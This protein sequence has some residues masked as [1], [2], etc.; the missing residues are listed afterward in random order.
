MSKREVWPPRCTEC[1][2][3]ISYADMELGRTVTYTP[4][5][6]PLDEEPPADEWMHRVCW[7][8]MGSRQQALVN[9]IAWQADAVI[10]EAVTA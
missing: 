8:R 5:G 1:G 9:R 7:D 2:R 3:F 10:R 4:Y 6:G